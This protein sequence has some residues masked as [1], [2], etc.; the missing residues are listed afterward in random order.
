MRE[1][2][3]KKG[4]NSVVFEERITSTKLPLASRMATFIRETVFELE[5]TNS[6]LKFYN[7]QL[8][9]IAKTDGLTGHKKR[10]SRIHQLTIKLQAFMR[11]Y[12]LNSLQLR[13]LYQRLLKA[14]IRKQRL[15][16]TRTLSLDQMLH[17]LTLSKYR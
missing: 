3:G 4:K 13:D 2:E 6:Q 10:Y 15:I 8:K 11:E 14:K 17:L 7:D 1:G 5:T 12:H 9:G 16:L